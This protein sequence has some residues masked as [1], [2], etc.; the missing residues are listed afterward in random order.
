ML[1]IAGMYQ[2]RQ[3][4]LDYHSSHA[5]LLS[6]TY[7]GHMGKENCEEDVCLFLFSIIPI[8]HKKRGKKLESLCTCQAVRFPSPYPL[9]E[10]LL[11]IWLLYKSHSRVRLC[12][13]LSKF[14][15]LWLQLC[16][17]D[18]RV[19][20]SCRRLTSSSRNKENKEPGRAGVYSLHSQMKKIK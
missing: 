15:L 20:H 2:L 12:L 19:Y 8:A 7:V 11:V 4:R 5:E 14:P 18:Q 10:N 13:S 3:W 16:P 9:R 1:E 17:I 6:C